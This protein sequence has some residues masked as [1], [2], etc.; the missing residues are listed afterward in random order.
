MEND[1]ADAAAKAAAQDTSGGTRLASVPTCRS[2]LRTTIHRHYVARLETQWHLAD[3]GCDLH[4]VMP[5]FSR[6][7]RWTADLSRRQVALTAQFLTGHYATN[8][9]LYRFGS[10]IDPSCGWCSAPVDDREHRIFHCPRFASLHLRLSMEV[11]SMI[12]GT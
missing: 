5:T 2:C 10:R 4:D 8:A 12:D 11:E 7:L 1:L 9:Y 3:T 6:C